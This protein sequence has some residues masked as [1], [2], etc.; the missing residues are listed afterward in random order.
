MK[1]T[2]FFFI[3]SFVFVCSVRAQTAGDWKW[4]LPT[5]AGV[6][7]VVR[8]ET[9]V[10][11]SDFE[12]NVYAA[13]KQ[14]GRKLWEIKSVKS[15]NSY[16]LLIKNNIL[17]LIGG[18]KKLVQA[19]DAA[20]RK[21][22]WSQP[23]KTDDYY[24]FGLIGETLFNGEAELR[25]IDLTT[26]REKWVNTDCQNRCYAQVV[27]DKLLQ[28]GDGELYLVNS[29]NGATEWSFKKRRGNYMFIGS[30]AAAVFLIHN[31]ERR[32]T[33]YS[34]DRKSGAENWHF[35][36]EDTDDFSFTLDANRLYAAFLNSPRI[37]ALDTTTGK[38][39]WEYGANAER[40]ENAFDKPTVYQNKL[41]CGSREGS[42]YVFDAAT[43]KLLWEK[44]YSDTEL[45][46]P[47][48]V[49]NFG[50]LLEKNNL[51]KIDL[52]NG[53][54]FWKFGT[55]G[56]VE[57]IEHE[58]GVLY[59]EGRE[60]S[61]NALNLAKVERLARLKRP[62]G[63]QS[64]DKKSLE[65][66]TMSMDIGIGTS[67]GSL[68]ARNEQVVSDP[69]VTGE[70]IYFTVTNQK[71]EQGI[72]YE[73]DLKNGDKRVV[74]QTKTLNLSAPTVNDGVAYLYNL[75][76]TPYGKNNGSTLIAFDVVSGQIK[77]SA[78]SSEVFENAPAISNKLIFAAGQD[79]SVSAF[80]L[81]GKAVG[82]LLS[83]ASLLREK[84]IFGDE[85][86]IFLR[87]NSAA[88]GAVSLES[89]KVIWS[90]ER[91][92]Q[93]ITAFTESTDN[94]ILLAVDHEAIYKL[95]RQ[96]G[97]IL[98]KTAFPDDTFMSLQITD[99]RLFAV[100]ESSSAPWV[101][102][103]SLTDGKP[104]WD[105]NI[106]NYNRRG[107]LYED[108]ICFD[109]NEKFSCFAQSDGRPT[110]SFVSPNIFF[111]ASE[112]GIALYLIKDAKTKNA[113]AMQAVGIKTGKEIWKTNW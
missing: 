23:L 91:P 98:W 16:K 31:N 6:Y 52:T 17:V 57:D 93:W 54:A 69:F 77:W 37:F 64:P 90:F 108:T 102:A 22:L 21:P 87:Q 88:F 112:N 101:Q 109:Q 25:A 103:V 49:G 94:S 74:T 79:K 26:G 15:E 59:F 73:F 89:G 111:A 44:S 12:G 66:L 60:F 45:S 14:T 107:V 62:L 5:T 10:F 11:V 71:T 27:E 68:S 55:Y 86:T 46:S 113:T 47:L 105:A 28:I 40:F 4:R 84:F 83:D 1:K 58:N 8:N 2:A 85:K 18:D 106:K 75:P 51:H 80:D 43:G 19:I 81:N 110:T 92:G 104:L 72:L 78:K 7:S 97:A 53:K 39:I 38:L 30:N 24:K 67:G 29:A 35:T 63:M 13:D 48:I 20:T 95:D 100:R 82:S 65:R 70:K 96:T 99:G 41:Y 76:L 32:K 50:Y 42:L 61:Y 9:G 3:I 34:L 33:I 56:G 36:I